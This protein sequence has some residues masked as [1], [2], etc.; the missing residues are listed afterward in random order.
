MTNGWDNYYYILNDPK[1]QKYI[2]VV[3]DDEYESF[4]KLEYKWLYTGSTKSELLKK[5]EKGIEGTLM[6][7]STDANGNNVT[8]IIESLKK[9]NT[10]SVKTRAGKRHYYIFKI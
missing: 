4:H 3:S 9:K 8:K 6:W 2:S 7:E 1:N 5:L 10:V